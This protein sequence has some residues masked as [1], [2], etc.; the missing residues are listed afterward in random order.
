MHPPNYGYTAPPDYHDYWWHY[1]H[2]YDDDYDEYDDAEYDVDYLDDYDPRDHWPVANVD[3][4][5]YRAVFAGPDRDGRHPT[6]DGDR[7][8]VAPRRAG[9]DN[10][11]DIAARARARRAGRYGVRP[12]DVDPGRGDD[13]GDGGPDGPEGPT[14]AA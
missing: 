3:G 13:G 2:Q 9:G 11:I 14:P 6:I 5:T 12:D 7:R 8:D 10:V 4:A 1:E